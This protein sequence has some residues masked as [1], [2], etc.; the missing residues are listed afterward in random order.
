DTKPAGEGGPRQSR[1]LADLEGR[2]TPPAG[3][4]SDSRLGGVFEFEFSGALIQRLIESWFNS[5]R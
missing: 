5:P 2:V 1:I 3:L 4:V